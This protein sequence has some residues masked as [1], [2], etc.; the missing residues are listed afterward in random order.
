MHAFHSQSLDACDN[1]VEGGLNISSRAGG[2]NGLGLFM[3]Q[4]GHI[5]SRKTLEGHDDFL[6]KVMLEKSRKNLGI[7]YSRKSAFFYM[8]QVFL[9]FI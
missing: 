8:I 6:Q 4:L 5:L 9:L 3:E 7:Y 1:G 2:H